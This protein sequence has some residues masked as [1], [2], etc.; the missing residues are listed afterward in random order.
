MNTVDG[1]EDLNGFN[2]AAARSR[3]IRVTIMRR[4][5]ASCGFNEA[6][7]GGGGI[8]VG[9]PPVGG[10]VELASMGPGQG[11]AEYPRRARLLRRLDTWLQ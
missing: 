5:R 11:A 3:G 9:P 2:E 8:L 6:A 4:P 7:G 10:A 1:G